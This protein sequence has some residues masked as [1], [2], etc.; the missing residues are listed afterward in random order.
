MTE[1]GQGVE[2]EHLASVAEPSAGLT[3]ASAHAD[4]APPSRD[5]TDSAASRDSVHSCARSYTNSELAAAPL[6]RHGVGLKPLS[7]LACYVQAVCRSV[8]GD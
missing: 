8:L 7:L 6:R 3:E 5:S 4:A 2:H 1:E